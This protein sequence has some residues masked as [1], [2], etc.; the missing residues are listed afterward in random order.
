MKKE[1]IVS[2][3]GYMMD[4]VVWIFILLVYAI[5]SGILLLLEILLSY[6]TKWIDWIISRSTSL[7]RR[8]K[9]YCLR[10]FWKYGSR[11]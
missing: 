5:Y 10:S 1:E 8:S 3:I 11:K 4:V 6:I 9:K 2:N 7:L